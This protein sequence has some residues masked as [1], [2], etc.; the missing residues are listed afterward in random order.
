MTPEIYITKKFLFSKKRSFF[1]LLSIIAIGGIAIGVAILIIAVL[2]LTG[3][4]NNIEKKIISFNDHIKITS[5]DGRDLDFNEN[6][7][8]EFSQNSVFESIIPFIS[9]NIIIRS[10]KSSE[11]VVL[12]GKNK[13]KILEYS[14]TISPE[15]N[16]QSQNSIYIG[17]KLA[18]KLGCLPGDEI[19]IFGLKNN[20]LSDFSSP[21]I[22][23]QLFVAGIYESG[24]YEY[25]DHIVYVD[26][27]YIKKL[28]ELNDKVTG[29]DIRLNDISKIEKITNDLRDKLPYPYYARSIFQVYQN[30][31]TWLELQKKPVPIVL[32]LIILVAAFNI[33][34]SMLM[35]VLERIKE[36]GTLK[37]LGSSRK[38][39]RKI[40]LLHG[41]VLSLIGILLGN[42]IALTVTFLQNQYGIIKLPGEIYFLTQVP[43]ELN[44]FL[45]VF[46]SIIAFLLTLTSALIPAI[47][48]SKIEII[49]S[50]RFS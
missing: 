20:S 7:F 24:M 26:F 2:I 46:V 33:V 16:V 14:N 19:I 39:I 48:A 13:S 25:D 1:S 3:F 29:Y 41:L 49:K 21:P 8:S 30:I 5:F 47:I 15:Q 38:S 11:G 17:A 35:V 10:R 9:R 45:N 42:V 27:T 36:I 6:P 23:D 4:E 28:F 40:F 37:T 32:G 22:I 44:L 31:F 50:L 43:I 12:I 34:G 18:D